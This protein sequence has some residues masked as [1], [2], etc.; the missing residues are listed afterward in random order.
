MEYFYNRESPRPFPL[1][2]YMDLKNFC[3][4]VFKRFSAT[5]LQSGIQGRRTGPS[6]QPRPRESAYQDELY[7]CYWLE[8]RN[9][10]GICSEW[11]GTDSRQIDFYIPGPKWGIELLRDGDRV[12]EH[13]NRFKPNGAYHTWVQSGLLCEWLVLDCRNRPPGKSCKCF[14]SSMIMLHE[15]IL[16]SRARPQRTKPMAGFIS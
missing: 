16:M 7:R 13:L 11:S 1:T 10:A 8:V 5:M 4:C 2:K 3:L 6:G 12:Q 14:L 9:G 15:F